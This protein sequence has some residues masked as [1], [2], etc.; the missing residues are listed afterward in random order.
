MSAEDVVYAY[1]NGLRTLD[2]SAAQKYSRNSLV[3]DTYSSYFDSKD[4]SSDY[5]DSFV[6]NMYKEVLLS[7]QPLEIVDTTLFAD[8]KQVFTVKLEVL[9][10]TSKDFWLQDKDTI[11]KNLYIYSNDENDS[12]KS[13]IYLYDYVLSYYRSPEAVTRTVD[14]NLTVEKYPDLDTGWL[15]SDDSELDAICKY[16]EGNLTVSYIQSQFNEY[17]KEKIK[18]ERD[19]ATSEATTEDGST[20]EGNSSGT[21]VTIE[22]S[23]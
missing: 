17:G 22:N 3:V 15:V 20:T 10:L 5:Y 9:D 12:A 19:D 16:K 23:Q 1:L 13:E 7:I 21:N 14:V 11:Y 8:N 2:I 6:R 18:Q 4:V